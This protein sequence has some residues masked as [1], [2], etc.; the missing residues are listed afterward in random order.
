MQLDAQVFLRLAEAASTICFWDL[1]ATGLKGDYNSIL[2]ISI[3]P[4]GKK[5]TTFAVT[6]PGHDKEVVQKA[7]DLLSQF[8]CWVGYYSKGF[9]FPMI[10]TRL[11]RWDLK[12][13][14]RKP[15]LDMYYTLK[16][17]LNTARRSQAHLIDW[18]AGTDNAA[19]LEKKM[20]L[21]AEEWNRVLENPKKGVP[22]M[23]KRC[24]SDTIGLEGL[25][26]RTRHLIRDVKA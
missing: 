9:D 5:P 16:A 22:V 20:S 17:H 23:I 26:R 18:L 3:K 21:S 13:L 4:F 24:E 10:Q 6:R 14:L 19:V 12:P 2:C 15:H 7:S 25:Y 11:L 1:E 8:D